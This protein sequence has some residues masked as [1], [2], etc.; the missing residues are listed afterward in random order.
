MGSEIELGAKDYELLFKTRRL[1]A[2][3]M[4]SADRMFSPKHPFTRTE[5][6]DTL[7]M[8]LQFGVVLKAASFSWIVML[9]VWPIVVTD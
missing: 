4:I 7:E 2:R 8:L 6:C 9:T 1:S 3:I 5:L